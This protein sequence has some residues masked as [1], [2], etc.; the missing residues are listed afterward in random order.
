M[1][2]LAMEHNQPDL[3]VLDGHDA[4]V[5]RNPDNLNSIEHT[6][7]CLDHAFDRQIRI[8]EVEFKIPISFEIGYDLK[9]VVEFKHIDEAAKAYKQLQERRELAAVQ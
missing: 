2:I 9:N 6:V 8:G 4:I 7:R 1:G 5:S 3:V